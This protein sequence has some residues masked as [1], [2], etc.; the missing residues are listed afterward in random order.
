MSF[1]RKLKMNKNGIKLGYPVSRD[2]LRKSSRRLLRGEGFPPR[3]RTREL[4]G[5]PRRF[6]GVERGAVTTGPLGPLRGSDIPRAVEND[7][8]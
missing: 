5:G 2:A 4:S 6:G 1:Q 3:D 7:R 8:A